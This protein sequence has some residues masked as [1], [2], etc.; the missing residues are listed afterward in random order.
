MLHKGR[1][2][3]CLYTLTIAVKEPGIYRVQDVR[4]QRQKMFPNGLRSTDL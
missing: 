1:I 3:N 4:A 2:P